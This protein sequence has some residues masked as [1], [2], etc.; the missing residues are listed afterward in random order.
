[1]LHKVFLNENR[2]IE[3]IL[4]G[5]INPKE[6]IELGKAVV[7]IAIKKLEK[8]EVLLLVRIEN[9][10][11]ELDS[12]T[13]K[14]NFMV[15]R[16]IPFSKLAFVAPVEDGYFESETNILKN[17]GRDPDSVNIRMFTSTEKAVA[18]LLGNV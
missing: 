13:L 9:S 1:M 2:I 5:P 11:G 6:V 7:D 18:W 17:A 8:E 14:S 3:V 16:D 4:D 10:P 15:Y 12:E